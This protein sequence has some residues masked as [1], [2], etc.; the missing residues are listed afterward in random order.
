[1]VVIHPHIK[2]NDFY[3]NSIFNYFI[4]WN[5]F[6]KCFVWDQLVFLLTL[7]LL[8]GEII[9]SVKYFFLYSVHL[10][11][12]FL[13]YRWKQLSNSHVTQLLTLH[14]GEVHFFVYFQK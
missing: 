2:A 7:V 1:M 5:L 10:W 12:K 9:E 8:L 6:L 3:K 4:S 13:S 11:R 14:Y